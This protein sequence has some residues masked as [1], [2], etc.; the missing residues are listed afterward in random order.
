MRQ[1]CEAKLNLTT[2]NFEQKI[3]TLETQVE[4]LK[5]GG[6]CIVDLLFLT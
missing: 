1:E 6:V 3:K 4:E 5:K 2:T